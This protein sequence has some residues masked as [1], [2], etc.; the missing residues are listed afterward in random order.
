MASTTS[1]GTWVQRRSSSPIALRYSQK[2]L[3]SFPPLAHWKGRRMPSCRAT[4]F[5]RMAQ[6]LSRPP[7]ASGV[8]RWALM[9]T[10]RRLASVGPG[11]SCSCDTDG[12]CGRSRLPSAAAALRFF[13]RL[14][15]GSSGSFQRSMGTLD[16]ARTPRRCFLAMWSST[17][18]TLRSSSSSNKSMVSLYSVGSKP[19]LWICSRRAQV[20][21]LP[22][23]HGGVSA[24]REQCLIVCLAALFPLR[25]CPWS[26]SVTAIDGPLAGGLSSSAERAGV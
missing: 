10:R 19:M 6:S 18:S 5:L 12:L 1:A 16:E 9:S 8:L 17:S 11:S 20:C 15:D 24:G 13:G 21:G 22:I 2:A 7:R 3:V 4:S 25:F 26:V 14:W 23:S